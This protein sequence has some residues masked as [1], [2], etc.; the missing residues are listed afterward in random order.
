MLKMAAI[1]KSNMAAT[2]TDGKNGNNLIWVPG[3]LLHHLRPKTQIV[4]KP[5]T[6]NISNQTIM[7]KISSLPP[8]KIY[9]TF[10]TGSIN[11]ERNSPLAVPHEIYTPSVIDISSVLHG[12]GVNFSWSCSTCQ[13]IGE[14]EMLLIPNAL[15]WSSRKCNCACSLP[16][17]VQLRLRI[18]RRSWQKLFASKNFVK[19]LVTAQ[20]QLRSYSEQQRAFGNNNICNCTMVNLPEG[21]L[22]SN[23]I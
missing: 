21:V 6:N 17:E 14:L 2:G 5:P 19:I 16:A 8:W 23:G 13:S 10:H 22:I 4:H 18:T 1:L 11:F 12:W 7:H 9:Q 15:C 20:T 3:S